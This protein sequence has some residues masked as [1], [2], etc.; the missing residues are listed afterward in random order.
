MGMGQIAAIGWK[1]SKTVK[2][3]REKTPFLSYGSAI[4]RATRNY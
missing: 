1:E 4:D 3:D 2:V